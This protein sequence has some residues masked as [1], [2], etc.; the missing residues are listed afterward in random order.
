M[1]GLM[2]KFLEQQ[3]ILSKTYDVCT[4]FGVWKGKYPDPSNSIVHA[5]TK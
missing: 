5:D 1:F 4:G 3:K 2:L